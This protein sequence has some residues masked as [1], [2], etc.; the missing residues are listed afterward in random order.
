MCW[1]TAAGSPR[2]ADPRYRPFNPSPLRRRDDRAQSRGRS[3]ARQRC[4]VRRRLCRRGRA[5]RV[6]SVL[7]LLS[8]DRPAAGPVGRAR[9][10]DRADG[11]AVRAGCRRAADG[12]VV[13]AG[14]QGPPPPL[15]RNRLG[16]SAP[17]GGHYRH[18]DHE[19]GGAVGHVGA[20]RRAL[21]PGSLV[22]GRFLRDLD[23]GAGAGGGAAVPALH[24]LRHLARPGV[25]GAARCI[26]AF[27][28]GAGRA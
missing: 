7:S 18:F 12:V 4:F 11:G 10:A 26:L 23:A 14:G 22:L 16:Q 25:G 2:S 5:V 17:C 1:T 8:R 24:P 9:A 21:L 20:D 28:R 19:T 3:P 6:D 27:R 15:D 13:G